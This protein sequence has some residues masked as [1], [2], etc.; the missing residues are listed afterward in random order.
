MHEDIIRE[1]IV[2]I[3]EDLDVVAG[4]Q[5]LNIDVNVDVNVA[6]ILQLVEQIQ[7]TVFGSNAAT[8]A[9]VADISQLA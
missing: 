1:P 8:A 2:L 9:Q 6:T 7:T 4:G 5:G 3:D